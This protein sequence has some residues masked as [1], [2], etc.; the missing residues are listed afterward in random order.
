MFSL[1]RSIK[2]ILSLVIACLSALILS[3][4]SQALNIQEV[5]NP[6]QVYGGW[7][8]DMANILS[9]GSEA[10]LNQ[11]ISQLEETN[12]TEI[13]VVTVQETTPAASP[14]E[15]ATE[16]FNSWGIGKQGQ[17]N[18]VL[19][20]TSVGDRRVE[21]ET[22]YGVEGILPD[23]RL[24][25]IIQ[26]EIIPR[27]KEGNMEAGIVGGTNALVSVLQGETFAESP[28]TNSS[29]SFFNY[30]ILPFLSLG[31]AIFNYFPTKSLAKQPIYVSPTGS[32]RLRGS[33]KAS[34]NFYIMSWLTTFCVLFAP[35]FLISA[36]SFADT[37]TTI[38]IS[39]FILAA[40]IAGVAAFP[41]SLI[42]ATVLFATTGKSSRP[43]YCQDCQKEMETFNATTLSLFLTPHQK[44]AQELGSV[45]FAAWH[46]PHCQSVTTRD[47]IHLR[48]Y[49]LGKWGYSECPVGKELT[50]TNNSQILTPATYSHSGTRLNT[51]T[52]QCCDYH[53][54]KKE[55]IPRKV[56][57]SSSSSS[58]G[59]SSGGY[60]SGSSS[61]GY[62]GGSSS[63]GGDFGGGDSGGGGAGG[64]W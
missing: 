59:Y 55:T 27:F 60:S 32:E 18:G 9:D 46:C 40:L 39:T 47:S 57:S 63:G 48:A 22:G 1:P 15:F 64:D 52:C 50:V 38:D 51:Y 5:P 56:R 53:R 44:K 28:T 31:A 17:D 7:V 16:L 49:I 13:A 41:L 58:G 43:I 45:K 36:W 8:T 21:I 42:I 25:S 29:N 23:S 24:G 6:Q 35:A 34:V 14:K 10:E 11:I 4:P 12:G 54:E 33:E 3:S 19:F 62:S 37:N 61:G 30:L 20:L 2:F 26:G